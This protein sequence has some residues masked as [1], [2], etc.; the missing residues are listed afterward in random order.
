[1]VPRYLGTKKKEAKPRAKPRHRAPVGRMLRFPRLAK[2]LR[3]CLGRRLLLAHGGG[4]DD[5]LIVRASA[6]LKSQGPE[7]WSRG[8]PG[9][10]TA[11]ARGGKFNFH[12]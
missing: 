1:M 9:R 4:D 10:H 8:R 2:V 7:N 5:E 11:E 6:V 3:F 12:P